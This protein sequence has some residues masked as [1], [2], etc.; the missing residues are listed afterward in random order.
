[1]GFRDLGRRIESGARLASIGGRRVLGVDTNPVPADW[2]HIT[3]VDPETDKSMPLA[4]SLYLSHTDAVSV[5]GSRGVTAKNTEDTFAF[6]SPLAVPAFHEPSAARH[7][8]Q[9]TSEE[10]AFLAVPEVLNGDSEALI[11][12]LGEGLDYVREE[13]GP[14]MIE[15]KIGIS[16]GDGPLGERAVD[17][18]AAY[19]MHE[20]VFEAYIIMNPDSAAA[21]EANV[22]EDDLL[23]PDQARKRALAAEYHLESEVIYL[24]YSGTFGGDEAVSLLTEIDDAV[25]WGRIWY[26]GG[27]D[28][29]ENVETVLAAGADTVVV[30]DIFHDI[31]TVERELIQAARARFDASSDRSDVQE[32]VGERLTVAESP[33]AK[34]L[35][36]IPSVG[37]PAARATEYLTTAVL[38]ALAVDDLG[39]SIDEPTASELTR[40]VREWAI[41]DSA[42]T[43]LD[44]T[45]TAD[46]A[47]AE[48]ATASVETVTADAGARE[49]DS[50]LTQKLTLALLGKRF[51]VETPDGF[52]GDHL[53]VE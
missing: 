23:S 1:M 46:T 52:S 11:G 18:V 50:E 17:A 12:V 42:D 38:L 45:V 28:S 29:R 31:A 32:W 37:N 35:A 43:A 27:L 20:A 22:T 34:Y 47:S 39:S 36:T 10:M 13:L 40:K 16:L 3:K 2:T 26:G 25:S 6:L 4:F 49:I 7:V 48:R 5:G 14:E 9:Q 21:R 53:A 30:G 44:E 51:G 8:T 15:E 41:V 19:L 24:E 33:A